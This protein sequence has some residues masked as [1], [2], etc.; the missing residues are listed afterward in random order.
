M[1]I[2]RSPL[3]LSLIFS[4]LL[5]VGCGHAAVVSSQDSR[6]E[7]S[8]AQQAELSAVTAVLD[9]Q[10]P[11][12]LDTLTPA[13]VSRRVVYVGE[14]HDDYA[15]HKA[16]LA[17]IEALYRS[18][19]DLAIGME[20]FQQPYQSHLDDYIAGNI[21]ESEM[22]RKTEWY[23]RW[24]YD[25]RHYQPILNFARNNGIPVIA[26]N[27]PRELTGQ[28]SREGMESLTAQERSQLPE[29]I[30][31][32]DQAY[33][34]RLKKVFTQHGEPG[35]RSFDR[36]LQIQLLWDEGMAQRAA[37]YLAANPQKQMVVLAGSGHLMHSSGIPNRVKRRQQVTSAV[38]L[39]GGDLKIEPGIAD[40]IVFPQAA[41]LP[42]AAV[43][44][45]Y[46]E[47]AE[48]GVLV[49]DVVEASAAELGGVRP[50]DIMLA[51]DGE[52]VTSPNDL[53]IALLGKKPGDDVRLTLIRKGL[54]FGEKQLEVH[55]T[56]GQ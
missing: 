26:L 28:V 21:T 55:L 53:R 47:K 39:P 14:I 5:L 19:A 8:S 16:Q 25:Y 50:G 22:L 4:S 35:D 24:V 29:D 18:G 46:M 40:F 38:V 27:V 23:E 12:G 32:S 31:Y 3:T 49:R 2:A 7:S 43:M 9:L 54:L 13:L 10:R 51:L 11:T 56:L 1:V 36:F 6:S 17:V 33:T 41:E 15:H 20:M 48:N 34:D 37:S 44:G 42:P 45:V 52:V 30:D